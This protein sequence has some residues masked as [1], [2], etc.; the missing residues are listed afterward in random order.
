MV[1]IA[2][3]PPDFPVSPRFFLLPA[4]SELIRIYNPASKYKTQ[5]LT[6]R[7]YGPIHRF[8][9]QRPPR[10]DDPE[11][12]IWYAA[13][14]L[15]CCVVEYFQARV[16]EFGEL[17]VAIAGVTRELQLLDLQGEGAMK[18]GCNVATVTTADTALT[19]DW[20]RYFYET[21]P[22][23]DG[24]IYGSAHNAEPAIALYERGQDA[25]RST[26]SIAL[27]HPDLRPLLRDIA[28]ENNLFFL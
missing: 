12:G 15:S 9:H 18:A 3:P 13:Q 25:L 19:Q 1:S 11:R 28:E 27:A 8:D 20:S 10:N 24:L 5:A 2:S 23:I 6:F 22:E 14:T 26:E 21:Y 16:I 17:Q 4:G 7:T